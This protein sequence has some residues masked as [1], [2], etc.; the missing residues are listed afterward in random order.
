MP[1]HS[2]PP[3]CLPARSSLRRRRRRRWRRGRTATGETFDP[4]PPGHCPCPHADAEGRAFPLARPS[5]RESHTLRVVSS[6]LTAALLA[7]LLLASPS[8]HCRTVAPVLTP[9]PWDG[10][11]C[12]KS[13]LEKNRDASWEGPIH[14]SNPPSRAWFILAPVRSVGRTGL[15]LNSPL[16]SGLSAARPGLRTAIRAP[17]KK[18]SAEHVRACSHSAT[19]T[20]SPRL[21]FGLVWSCVWLVWHCHARSRPG[22]HY[23]C[24]SAHVGL[25]YA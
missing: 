22:A 25:V 21:G 3:A 1:V 18:M 23:P 20:R 13:G 10:C 15:T 24:P 6:L 4:C 19:L 7:G 16:L 5:L 9:C 2:C 14:P 12:A 8:G 17:E 11:R